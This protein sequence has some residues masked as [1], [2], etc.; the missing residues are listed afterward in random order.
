MAQKKTQTIMTPEQKA[1]ERDIKRI[2][3]RINEIAKTY[4]TESVSYQKYY[5]TI[6]STV[7]EKY[8]K[9]SK[10]GIIQLSRSKEFISSISTTKTQRINA[11][12]LGMK[13]KGQLRKEARQSLKEEGTKKPTPEEIELRMK[14]IDRVNKYVL[15]HSEMFYEVNYSEETHD[16]IHIRGRRKTYGELTHIV[17][18]FDKMEEHKFQDVFEGL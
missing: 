17:N 8:R 14:E 7:P 13:T 11:R 16:M 18:E 1:F 3:E 9:V 4:G 6:K 12:L 10:H 2:N 15:E 5:S